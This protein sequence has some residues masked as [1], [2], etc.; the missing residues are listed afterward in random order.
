M[1]RAFVCLSETLN[2]SRAC[3]EL[4]A[5]RQTVRRHITELEE[6]KGGKLFR[7]VDRQYQLTTLGSASLERAKSILR[8]VDAWSGQSALTKQSLDGMESSRYASGDGRIFYSQQH[9]ISKISTNGSP[10]L[11][12][13]FAAWG[14]AGTR[15]EDEAM[16]AIR[17]FTV[18]Y[19]K[20]ADGWIFVDIGE[21]SAYA[22]WF[23]WTWSKSAVGKLMQDDN[24]GD[25]FNEFI[26]GAY[27]R[28][29]NEG[30][31]RLDH[32]IAHLPKTGLSDLVPVTFHRL[33]MGCVF[34]DDTPG[35]LVLVVITRDVE[36]D[37]VEP[38]DLPHMPDEFLMDRLK[39]SAD[40]VYK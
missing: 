24:V 35:L 13:T 17:P 27:T 16:K 6:I 9:P 10:L 31:V 12:G 40:G 23:G 15:V 1:L 32:L 30:G 8:D 37:A 33:L 36:I 2:L 39:P 18:L 21:R 22:E 4:N 29:F 25:E 34:P 20:S 3:K 7:V 5:T 14:Q 38:S 26:A 11:Q 19:R 28:I